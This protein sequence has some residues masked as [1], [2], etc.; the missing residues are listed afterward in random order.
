MDPFYQNSP[1]FVNLLASQ[2]TQTIDLESP[3]IPRFSSQTSEDPKPVERRKWTTKQD[4]ILISAW[5]NTSKDPIVSN[6]QKAGAFW[7]RIE[8]Y[9]NSSPQLTGLPTRE[10][11]QCKQRW[12]R[13]NEQVC[14]FVGCYEAA[15]KEQA[16]GQN[17]ND[18]M[19]AAHDIFENDYHAKFCLEHAWRELRFDQK[20][21]SNCGNK[22][23]AKDKRKEP[24]EVVPDLEEVRPPGV[25]ASKAAKRK[26]H[27]NEAA[28]DQLESMLVVK[29]NISKHRLLERLLARKET[30]SEIEVSLMNKLITEL[31]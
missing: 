17:D 2:N 23:G 25:K 22:D 16:S 13:L 24:A 14:K 28:Y 4:T 6:E 10:A 5:L 21:R 9:Y 11:S 18:V 20:W 12:G 15:V 7:K 19:K 27:G 3:E 30:L 1:G 31:L 26:K 29:E 8:E